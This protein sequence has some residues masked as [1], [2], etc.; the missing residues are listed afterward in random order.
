MDRARYFNLLG[1]SVPQVRVSAR[2]L[3]LLGFVNFYIY[4]FTLMKEKGRQ[5]KFEVEK[6]PERQEHAPRL[7]PAAPI[8]LAD[9][10]NAH[11]PSRHRPILKKKTAQ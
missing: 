2:A 11:Y 4:I 10:N 6:I 7:E 3:G 1:E 9:R 8:R 5:Y